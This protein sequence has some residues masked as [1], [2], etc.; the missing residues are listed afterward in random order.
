MSDYEIDSY[1]LDHRGASRLDAVA[2]ITPLPAIFR[3]LAKRVP[4]SE[5]GL[6]KPIKIRRKRQ[7]GI[8][9]DAVRRAGMRGTS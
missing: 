4:V 9:V 1:V 2:A 5:C 7:H 6:F 3:S 8:G